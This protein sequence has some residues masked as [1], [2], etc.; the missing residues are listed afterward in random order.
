MFLLSLLA[1]MLIGFSTPPK[2]AADIDTWQ[3]IQSAHITRGITND[4]ARSLDN[5]VPVSD[6]DRRLECSHTSDGGWALK[7]IQMRAICP[8][9]LGANCRYRA[10]YELSTTYI[11]GKQT[12]AHRYVVIGPT[13]VF[14]VETKSYGRTVVIRRPLFDRETVITCGDR[15][16]D[17]VV[18][19]ALRQRD[20]VVPFVRAAIPGRDVAVQPVVAVDRA[21]IQCSWF[22]RPIVRGVRWVSA[23][24]VARLLR[25]AGA[26][27]SAEEIASLARALGEGPEPSV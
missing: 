13:G 5:C 7:F 3:I 22:A 10:R 2:D 14:T 19:Q 15:Q 1:T 16:L 27:L 24:R 26:V 6:E 8:V 9:S 12:Y 17:G 20:A 4:L 21:E 25:S 23:P 11:D 18:D